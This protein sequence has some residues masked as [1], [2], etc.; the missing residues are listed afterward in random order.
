MTLK[1]AFPRERMYDFWNI[2]MCYLIH[3]DRN[4]PEKDRKLFGTLANRMI[5]KAAQAGPPD[6][7]DARSLL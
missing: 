5:S 3:E 6:K 2:L 7:V 4:V 1:K